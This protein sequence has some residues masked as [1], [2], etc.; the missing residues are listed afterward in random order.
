MKFV[1][2]YQH[3]V[4]CLVFDYVLPRSTLMS[5]IAAAAAEPPRVF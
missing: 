1:G 3:L 2:V 4:V 5:W